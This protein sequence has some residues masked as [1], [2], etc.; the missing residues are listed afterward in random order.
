M[1]VKLA[2]IKPSPYNPKEPLTKKEY[3]ALKR[4][5][6]KYGFQRD[7]LIC[8]DFDT[9][10]GYYCLDG[11]TALQLFTDLGV[12]E[13]SCKLVDNVTDLD[14][15]REFISAWTISKKP[16]YNEIYKALGSRMEEI[17][18]QSAKFFDGEAKEKYEKTLSSAVHQTQ[19]FLTLP[20]DCVTRLKTF[21]RTKAFKENKTEAIC[22]KID[23]MNDG[24]FLENLFQI[25]L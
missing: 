24:Q 1:T 5:V 12:M 13:T 17:V 16:L 25:I 7:L 14:T 6:E 11:H 10:I 18:G 2:E 20:E 19:Y 8:K 21:V 22:A 15:L 3:S 23:Q 9:G 4:N